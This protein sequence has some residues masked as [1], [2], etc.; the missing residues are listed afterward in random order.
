MSLKNSPGFLLNLSEP[1]NERQSDTT[2]IGLSCFG[3]VLR[4]VRYGK[5]PVQNRR[6]FDLSGG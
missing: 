6:D 2:S 4:N 1:E 5:L 3:L